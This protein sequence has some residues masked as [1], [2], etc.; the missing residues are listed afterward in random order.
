V[1]RAAAIVAGATPDREA[2]TM[3]AFQLQHGVRYDMP[4][5]F[6]PSVAPDTETGFDVH[7]TNVDFDTDRDA[8]EALLPQW[9]RA[10]AKPVVTVGYRHMRNMAWMGNRDY[11]IVSVS[12]SA[13]I[14]VRGVTE[15]SGF[16]LVLWESD[17]AP[18]MAGRELM[19]S[20]KLLGDIPTQAVGP[21]GHDF[22]LREY[23]ATLIRGRVS[24]LV[25]LD[26]EEI[27]QRREAQKRARGFF[28]KY[29]P[30]MDGT[31][32]VD[33]PVAITMHTPFVRMWR[34]RGEV[35]FCTPT[36]TEAPYSSKVLAVLSQLPRLSE[37]RGLSWHAE[38]CTLFRSETA[39]L[40]C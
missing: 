8:V 18:V 6:G 24:D 33:Y 31:A 32:D 25:A 9:F 3:G 26:D 10:T 23:D 7:G 19:G 2:S 4:P 35:E 11:R 27:A 17:Y 29:I 5:S 1:R 21:D 12:V 28:W 37:V 13:E 34:G 39:R 22:L 38:G 16:A 20:P 14:D 30:G 40:D 15:T 36:A